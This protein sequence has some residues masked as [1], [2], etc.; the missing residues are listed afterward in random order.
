[1]EWNED[2]WSCGKEFS[3]KRDADGALEMTNLVG[4]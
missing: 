1:M 2:A 4:K 3:L